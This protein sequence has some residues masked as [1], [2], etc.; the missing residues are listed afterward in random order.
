MTLSERL[1]KELL[2]VGDD[3]G[4]KPCHRIAFKV[5]RTGDTREFETGGLCESALVNFFQM[6]LPLEMR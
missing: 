1:A 5:Y 3:R 4:S 2:K 6:R